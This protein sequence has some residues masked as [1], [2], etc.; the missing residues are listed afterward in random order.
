M[1]LR[2]RLNFALDM[3][4]DDYVF[5]MKGG[6]TFDV[7]SFRKNAWISAFKKAGIPYKVPFTTRHSFAAWALTLGFDPNRL[8]G[9]MGHASEKMIYGVYGNYVDGPEKDV[10]LI[11]GYFSKGFHD[12]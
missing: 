8:V 2:K 11:G 7:D 6:R 1:E 10:E 4:P 3:A 5:T 9:L 12:L